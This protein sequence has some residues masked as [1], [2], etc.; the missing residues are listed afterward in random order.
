MVSKDKIFR[1]DLRSIERKLNDQRTNTAKKKWAS[2]PWLTLA[3]LVVVVGIFII[4]AVVAVVVL[5]GLIDIETFGRSEDHV[6]AITMKR[7]LAAKW[8]SRGARG[9]QRL[10]SSSIS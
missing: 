1:R 4:G 3:A 10:R 6:L 5:G 8:K 9:M 7:E 2:G